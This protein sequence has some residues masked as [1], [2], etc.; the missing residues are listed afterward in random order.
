MVPSLLSPHRPAYPDARAPGARRLGGPGLR[1][2]RAAY[3]LAT[4]VAALCAATGAQAV[5]AVNVRPD[6]AAIDLT[7]AVER[8]QTEGDRIQVST[9]P[10]TDGIVRRVEVRAREAGGNW[11]AF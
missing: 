11:A 2:L 6:V 9:A 5:Q 1:C 4:L 10:G 8:Q 3:A 7:E